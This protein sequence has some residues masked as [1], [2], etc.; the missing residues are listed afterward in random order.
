MS[1]SSG[2]LRRRSERAQRRLRDGLVGGD[3]RA[4]RWL[5]GEFV[6]AEEAAEPVS[7]SNVVVGVRW[8]WEAL[9]DRRVLLEGAV[10]QP[11]RA[12]GARITLIPALRK[13]SSDAAVNLLSWSRIRKRGRWSWSGRVMIRLR[14]CCATQA[15]LGSRGDA[16]E[17]DAATLG[18]DVEE[19]VQASQPERLDGE[20]VTL[21]D[22]GG[23]S[24]EELRP[25]HACS[26][27]C[28]LNAVKAEDVPDAA[29]GRQPDAERVSDFLCIRAV[30]LR[31]GS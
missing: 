3:P 11:M 30:G 22:P 27:R 29:A 1:A 28:R 8:G 16:G 24:A 13:I 25:A 14:A 9:E 15:H 2:R 19:H 7:A 21:E 23:M 26:P 20:E 6:L 5:G 10:G 18:L 4:R 12:I 17:M 31:S